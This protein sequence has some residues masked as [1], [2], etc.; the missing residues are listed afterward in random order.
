MGKRFII[1]MGAVVLLVVFIF[2]L[3]PKKVAAPKKPPKPPV[4]A[5]IPPKLKADVLMIADFDMGEKPN[6]IGGDFGAWNKDPDDP[7][8]GCHDFFTS[9]EKYGREGYAIALRY[10][11][12]S[13]N[14]AYN[15]FWMKLENLDAA[16]YNKLA[17]YIKGDTEEGYPQ[18]IKIEFKN[19]K[20]EVGKVYVSQISGTWAPV[21]V[22]FSN[23]KGIKDFS[24]MTEFVIVF[25]DR[26]T[27][28]KTGTIYIDNIQFA[29]D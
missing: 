16:Q 8:Q 15:G 19:N 17:F 27:K 24:Q 28:P 1:F 20:G 22:P 3:A 23:F 21:E 12:D 25:E 4:E 18:K 5:K 2:A 6:N 14:P 11:V 13:P 29:R 10:D 7:T 9:D 26:V